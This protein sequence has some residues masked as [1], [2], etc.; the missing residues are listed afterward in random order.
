MGR[1]VVKEFSEKEIVFP[2]GTRC[3]NGDEAAGGG[4][5]IRFDVGVEGELV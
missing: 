1:K 3:G 5:G 4:S 2:K